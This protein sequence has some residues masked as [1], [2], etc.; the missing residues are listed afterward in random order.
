MYTKKKIMP[1]KNLLQ[2][3][4]NMKNFKIEKSIKIV[5]GEYFSKNLSNNFDDHI[6][7]SIPFYNDFLKKISNLSNFFE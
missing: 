4:S 6:K 5:P 7:K 3:I 1:Q 2:K